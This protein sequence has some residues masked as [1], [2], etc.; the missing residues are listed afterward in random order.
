MAGGVAQKVSSKARNAARWRQF[1]TNSN[2]ECI[3][4]TSICCGRPRPSC[5]PAIRRQRPACR[6]S[7]DDF[8]DMLRQ[9]TRLTLSE[10]CCVPPKTHHIWFCCCC[11]C[12][13]CCRR[14]CSWGADCCC[15][16]ARNPCGT[17]SSAAGRCGDGAGEEVTEAARAAGATAAVWPGTGAVPAD[18]ADAAAC[19]ELATAAAW[20]ASSLCRR[21]SCSGTKARP[22]A[23]PPLPAAPAAAAAAAAA[24]AAGK[25]TTALRPAP[26]RTL[27]SRRGRRVPSGRGGS[28]PSGCSSTESPG[29]SLRSATT[30][31]HAACRL[32]S[33]SSGSRRGRRGRSRSKPELVAEHRYQ[34]HLCARCSRQ[35]SEPK[36]C[37]LACLL[38]DLCP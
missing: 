7:Y 12:C 23:L 6:T 22:A 28:R 21:A 18:A 31:G 10:M 15:T 1:P 25:P 24:P 35:C 27:S 8:L 34:P 17:T 38:L 2:S 20:W 32:S 3:C 14:C 33:C 11:C 30:A 29:A 36:S 5:S 4:S 16:P 37:A 19:R 9:L 26:R 13:C